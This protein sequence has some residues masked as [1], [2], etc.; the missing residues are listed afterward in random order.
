[1]PA[2]TLDLLSWCCC[3]AHSRCTQLLQLAVVR[4]EAVHR[5][6]LDTVCKKAFNHALKSAMLYRVQKNTHF[7]GRVWI[8]FDVHI[9]PFIPL[10]FTKC[11]SYSNVCPVFRWIFAHSRRIYVLG[12]S[13]ISSLSFDVVVYFFGFLLLI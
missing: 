9:K 7:M 12:M 3:C 8:G 4:A 1:M 13:T 5:R 10:C 2:N 11:V 6:A